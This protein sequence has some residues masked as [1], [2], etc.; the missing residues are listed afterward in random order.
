MRSTKGFCQADRGA[1]TTSSMPIAATRSRKSCPYDASRSRSGQKAGCGV[2]RECLGH[3][4]CKPILCGS[5]GDV[6]VNDR[7]TVMAEDDQAIEKPKGRGYNNEHVDGGQA[8][9]VIAQKRAPGR[10]GDLGPLQH[11][12]FDRGLAD[13][14]TELEQFAM[15]AG[16]APKWIGAAHLPDQIAGGRTHPRPSR[17]AGH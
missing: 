12:F 14:D 1:V 15:D 7:S 2:P 4:A 13:F 16:R 11:A 10:G 9:H 5:F 8:V 17:S 6:E 3:L